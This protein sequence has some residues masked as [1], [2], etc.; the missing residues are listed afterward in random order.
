MVVKYSVELFS[1][2]TTSRK[3]QFRDSVE[4]RTVEVEEEEEEDEESLKKV[5][6]DEDK[7]RMALRLLHEGDP[8][9]AVPDPA[10]LASLEGKFV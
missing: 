10:E 9:G 2:E 7:M 8:T 1:E 4:I 5:E 3:V 6:I